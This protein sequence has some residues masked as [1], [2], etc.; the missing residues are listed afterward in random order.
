MLLWSLF[1]RG[2][3]ICNWSV[4]TQ[5]SQLVKGS[6]SYSMCTVVFGAFDCSCLF[7]YG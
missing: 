1:F 5:C 7:I 3:N 4:W 6:T 2:S